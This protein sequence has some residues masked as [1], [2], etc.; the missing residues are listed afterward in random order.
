MAALSR[1]R[2]PALSWWYGNISEFRNE[3]LQYLIMKN[4]PAEHHCDLVAYFFRTSF[5]LLRSGG[6]LGLIATNTDI[7]GDTRE[8]GLGPILGAGGTI[9]R[10]VHRLK[11]PESSG[12]CSVIHI[13][14]GSP[15]GLAE[16]DARSVKRISAYLVEGNND[17]SPA[18]LAQN[19]Y[20]SL[21]SK[22]YG[23]G[24]LL[25]TTI[26]RRPPYPVRKDSSY[27]TGSI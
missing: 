26:R 14:N 21:G 19:P 12:S 3:L 15:A 11:W 6:C 5:R 8:G 1:R 22:I 9:F 18:P 24:F 25:M 16:L 10:A 23:Q 7:S 17:A 27:A 4:V 2:Q 13:A 20:Y